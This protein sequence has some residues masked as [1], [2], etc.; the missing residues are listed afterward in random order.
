MIMTPATRT[1][2]WLPWLIGAACL[3]L[4]A[5]CSGSGGVIDYVGADGERWRVANDPKAEAPAILSRGS[6]GATWASVSPPQ[7]P[8]TAILQL[9]FIPLIGAGLILLGI[10]TLVMRSWLPSVPMGAS[11]AAMATGTILI[12]MPKIVQEGWWILA[13]MLIAVVAVYAISWFDNRCKL[14][15]QTPRTPPTPNLEEP[16]A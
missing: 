9:W 2:A 11:L 1:R 10:G 14:K 15:P 8:D 16:P 5:G 4:V 6:D 7:T 13:L 12:A 3:L